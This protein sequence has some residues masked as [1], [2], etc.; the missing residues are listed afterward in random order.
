MKLIQNFKY[1]PTVIIHTV[2][3]VIILFTY[4]IQLLLYIITLY[5]FYN[6][7]KYYFSQ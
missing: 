1:I 6:L 2:I 5:I 3:T 7:F 4:K